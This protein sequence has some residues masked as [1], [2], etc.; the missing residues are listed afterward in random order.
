MVTNPKLAVVLAAISSNMLPYKIGC[1]QPFTKVT[2]KNNTVV[3]FTNQQIRQK[4]K[5]LAS[6]FSASVC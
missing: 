6:I 5:A 1:S 2:L 3:V 4:T